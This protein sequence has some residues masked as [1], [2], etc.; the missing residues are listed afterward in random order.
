MEAPW[1]SKRIYQ[2]KCEQIP[3]IVENLGYIPD[4]IAISNPT[5][6]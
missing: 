2:T 5:P 4:G 1:A 3:G 6:Y